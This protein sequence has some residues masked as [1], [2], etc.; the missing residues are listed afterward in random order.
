M[1]VEGIR[2]NIPGA[3]SD[4]DMS[5]DQFKLVKKNATANQYTLCDTDGEVFHGVLQNKPAAANRGAEIT[6]F[7][8]TKVKAAEVLVPGNHIGTDASGL[9]KIVEVSITGADVGDYVGGF[10][11][12]GAS[13]ANALATALIGTVSF[14]VELQ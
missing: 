9:A 1:A 2:V 10:V 6:C 8:L 11:T 13:A 3:L 12:E 5:S 7:G 14:R 4:S